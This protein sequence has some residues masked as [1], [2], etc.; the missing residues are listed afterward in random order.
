[1]ERSKIDILLS[2]HDVWK[3]GS[4]EGCGHWV[5]LNDEPY[6]LDQRLFNILYTLYK[7]CLGNL[8]HGDGFMDGE[9]EAFQSTVS[10]K[11]LITS[12][13][14]ED[15]ISLFSKLIKKQYDLIEYSVGDINHYNTV[16]GLQQKWLTEVVFNG[17]KLIE[18]L[19]FEVLKG[20]P[21]EQFEFPCG[22]SLYAFFEVEEM[23]K[24]YTAISAYNKILYLQQL[25]KGVGANEN[26]PRI[27]DYSFDE[28]FHNEDKQNLALFVLKKVGAIDSNACF[29]Y[30]QGRGI[31]EVWT[32]FLIKNSIMMSS[33][34]SKASLART[35]NKKIHNL[36]LSPTGMELSEGYKSRF[37]NDRR[38]DIQ[39][40]MKLA[41]AEFKKTGK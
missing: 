9:A 39:D 26:K 4:S 37:I 5:Y 16:E 12:P 17:E 34:Y 36:K 1:M 2:H 24:V 14:K 31:V 27:K 33:G 3:D 40:T 15:R 8:E 10:N 30:K 28:L 11:L 13:T 25:I 21:L 19:K 6:Q 18:H 29:I 22:D 7:N 41:M 35:L 20:A 32:D 38:K 23:Q